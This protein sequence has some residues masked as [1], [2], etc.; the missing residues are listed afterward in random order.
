MGFHGNN[1]LRQLVNDVIKRGA[2]SFV[3]TGTHHADTT[4]Y[5]AGQFPTLPIFTC[6]IDNE[7]F[8][9]SLK[10]TKQ[11]ANVV[12]SNE[13]SEKFVNRLIMGNKLGDLPIFFL[14]A[15]WFDYWPLMDEI[16][17]IVLLPN[18]VIIIDDF[19]VPGQP[20]F[21]TSQGGGGSI[22][23]TRTQPDLRP[24]SME[25]IGH[26]LPKDC[27]IIYPKYGK[28]EAYGT[29]NTPHLVG[30]VVISKSE[31]ELFDPNDKFHSRG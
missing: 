3:E 20:Q 17:S 18:F 26:L 9:I 10:K 30:Y 27:K 14:D 15:H 4:S 6:E 12:L 5:V 16:A 28:I 29:P 13:S 31:I 24:C 11:F 23:V 22:G 25:L 19:A 21:E 1:I 7:C 8:M 2:S